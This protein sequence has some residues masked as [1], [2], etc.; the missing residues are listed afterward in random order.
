MNRK[1]FS[2][3]AEW[4]TKVGYSRA[5]KIGNSIEV[6]G[7]VALVNGKLVGLNDFYT[8]TKCILQIISNT[9]EKA[10]AKMEDVTRTRIYTTDISHWQEIGRAHGEVFAAIKPLIPAPII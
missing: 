10:G 5:V 4:E 2:T 1:I 6:S 3:G 7:T 9:L 8:Q